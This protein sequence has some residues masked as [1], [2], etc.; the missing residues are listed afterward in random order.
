MGA[1]KTL[2]TSVLTAVAVALTAAHAQAQS[3]EQ[4]HGMLN[5]QRQANGIPPAAFDATRANGCERHN[6]YQSLNGLGHG[7]DPSKPGYSPEGTNV[8]GFEVLS[9]GE[10]GWS[11]T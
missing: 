11:T 5:A 9:S 7:Q 8:A 3:P 2:V 6:Y 10:G 4:T 1:T